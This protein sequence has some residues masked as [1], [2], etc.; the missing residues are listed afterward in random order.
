MCVFSC[1]CTGTNMAGCSPVQAKFLQPNVKLLTKKY[2]ML[3]NLQLI[4]SFTLLQYD[5]RGHMTYIVY[6]MYLEDIC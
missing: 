1:T 6:H 4:N 2:I 5:V 3:Y